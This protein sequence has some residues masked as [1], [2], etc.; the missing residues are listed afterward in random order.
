MTG[1]SS[2]IG[3]EM[4]VVLHREGAR[5][6][7]GLEFSSMELFLWMLRRPAPQFLSDPGVPGARSMGPDVTK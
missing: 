1:A 4:A 7:H 6:Y 2:G 5:L 3:K